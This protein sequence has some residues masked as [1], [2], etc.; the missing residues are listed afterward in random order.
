MASKRD[1][2]VLKNKDLCWGSGV[3]CTLYARTSFWHCSSCGVEAYINK[4]NSECA[5]CMSG[6][7]RELDLSQKKHPNS[8]SPSLSPGTCARTRR[9]FPRNLIITL[10]CTVR[11]ASMTFS[12]L[13]VSQSARF[14]P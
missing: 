4:S 8:L 11:V 10:A 7:A 6:S 2:Y 13:E 1:G 14:D 12:Q 5:V 9:P 3:Y